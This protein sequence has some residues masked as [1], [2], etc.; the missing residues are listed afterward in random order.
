MIHSK[1]FRTFGDAQSKS[2]ERAAGEYASLW[3]GHIPDDHHY[4]HVRSLFLEWIHTMERIG[5]DAEDGALVICGPGYGIA[6]RDFNPEIIRGCLPHYQ[7]IVGADWSTDILEDFS[8]EIDA[9]SAPAADKVILTQRDFS[10]G[11]A[12]RFQT[13]VTQQLEEVRTVDDL[14]NFMMWVERTL[15]SDSNIAYQNV[16]QTN[17]ELSDKPLGRYNRN[18]DSTLDVIEPLEFDA[19]LMNQADV[20][21]LTANMLLAGMLALTENDVRNAI[22]HFRS[23]ND[24][25]KDEVA[26]GLEDDEVIQMLADWHK[27][28]CDFNTR[29]ATQF[30]LSGLD[31]NPN[32]HIFAPTD[33]NVSYKSRKGGVKGT[34]NRLDISTLSRAVTEKGYKFVDE[35]QWIQDDQ[36]ENP[37]HKHLMK[38][39]LACRNGGKAA[40][41][42]AD[43]KIILTEQSASSDCVAPPT[44]HSTGNVHDT[45]TVSTEDLLPTTLPSDR[46]SA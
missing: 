36:N 17:P 14:R 43:G 41:L 2:Y 32:I 3:E 22:M 29:I 46:K 16:M 1:H 15:G 34:F 9:E 13:I 12:S 24:G 38:L 6:G 19:V 7:S 8:T 18:I 45:M 44:D 37:P 27:V 33:V 26:G 11:I 31:L 10:F 21:F 39:L 42:S 23:I 28:V 5:V 40:G 20:R 35:D 30:M 25:S 4:T